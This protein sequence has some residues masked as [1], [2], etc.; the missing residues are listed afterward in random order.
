MSKLICIAEHRHRLRHLYF[1]R[2]ELNKLLS[3]YS[4]HVARGEW[5]DYAIDHGPGMAVFS[6]FR[7]SH[8]RPLFSI[9]KRLTAAGRPA[10]YLL[11]TGPKRLKSGSSIDEVLE[12][13]EPKLRIVS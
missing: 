2:R 11:L 8:E 7:H 1:D 13:L 4:R 5:R 6:V 12:I 9:A 10:D 3:L